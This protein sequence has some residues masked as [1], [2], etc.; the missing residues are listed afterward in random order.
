MLT[1]AATLP[2]MPTIL[3][4]RDLT[5]SLPARPARPSRH[6]AASRFTVEAGEFVAL[7][8]PSGSGKSHP[9]P[10]PRR[11]R[12]ADIR[13]GR[14]RGPGRQPAVR[15]RRD[16]TAS[17][18]D[19]L[20]LPVVQPDPAPR[21]RRERRRCRSRSPATTRPR[22]SWPSAI[23]DVIALVDLTGKE[24]HKP[25][26]LSAGEQQRVAIARALV[27]RPALLFADEPTGNLDYTTRTQN[28][29]CA[30]AL[31]RRARPDGRPRDPR[32][33]GGGVRRPRPGHRR[34]RICDTI[35]LGRRDL[36][37]VDA[38][39][40]AAG[41]PRPVGPSSISSE[42][43]RLPQPPARPLRAVLSAL[44]VP[45]ASLSCSP[46]W[47][48][49]R[50]SRHRC[51]APST[52]SSVDPTCAWWPSAKTWSERQERSLSIAGM[53]GVD[54]AAPALERRTPPWPA[55]SMDVAAVDPGH[56]LGVDPALDVVIPPPRL[57]ARLAAERTRRAQR[58]DHRA[59]RRAGR[60]D[61][62]LAAHDAGRRRP[63]R[64]YRV[65]GIVAGDGPLTGA[66]GR[67]VDRA[68]RRPPRPCSTRP[69]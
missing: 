35:E 50:A 63:G 13:R 16:A 27:T 38:T 11:A 34:R 62:R 21:R 48:P 61:R 3:E 4:A 9:P 52:T 68:A 18:P 66:F 59:P 7:M 10:G 47:P 31:M 5:K 45:R 53:P 57:V 36:H 25:D 65:I 37:D 22:A 49:A 26:Q 46:A 20:R 2:P 23:R 6:C 58:P 12:P 54:V 39:H 28:P 41:Q 60:A 8:G 44:G 64:R 33:K 32:F 14:P 56:G 19:R 55:A 51:G 42:E 30:V 67:T 1:P 17:R 69:A 40:R 29:R 15:R 24:H 43:P